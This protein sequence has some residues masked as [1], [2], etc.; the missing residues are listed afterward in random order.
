M[1]G[2]PVAPLGGRELA[3]LKC[4]SA[5]PAPAEAMNLRTIPDLAQRFGTVVGLSDHTLGASVAVA[6]VTLGAC[7]I[8]KHLTL[9]RADGGPDGSFSLEPG[10]FRAM[11]DSIRTAEAA[12]GEIRYGESDAEQE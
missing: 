2:H 5:Y 11:V 1:R 12:L 7:I 6:A 9:A 8:E 4:V 10:E 3:L